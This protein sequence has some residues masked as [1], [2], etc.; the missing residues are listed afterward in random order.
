[1]HITCMTKNGPETRFPMKRNLLEK[2]LSSL[3]EKQMFLNW[4][5]TTYSCDA[6]RGW[7]QAGL[8]PSHRSVLPCVFR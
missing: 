8:C 4:L 1:M 3:L 6:S 2:I 7:A 5:T